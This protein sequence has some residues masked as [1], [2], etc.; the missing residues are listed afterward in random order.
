MNADFKKI[1]AMF[2]LFAAGTVVMST[3]AG[4]ELEK[5]SNET[6]IAFTRIFPS[7]HLLRHAF[8]DDK[9]SQALDFFIKALDRER[10]YF[11][12]SDIDGFNRSR[13]EL[14]DMVKAGDV[15][16]VFDVADTW[17]RRISNRCD[18][19]IGIVSNGFDLSVD[20]TIERD[21]KDA[22]WP[23]DEANWDEIWRKRI[24]DD[25]LRRTLA[26]EMAAES[27]TNKTALTNDHATAIASGYGEFREIIS[28]TEP[29]RILEMFLSSI[30]MAYDPH[31]SYMSPQSEKDFNDEMKLSF[32]GIGAV[33]TSEGG[34]TKVDRV[35]PGGPADRDKRDICL[36]AGDKIIAVAQGDDGPAEDVRHWPVYRVVRLIRGKKGTKVVLTVIPVSDP[37]GTTTRRVDLV[38]DDIPLEQQAAKSE[39]RV[40]TNSTGVAKT[41]GI[42]RLPAFY[43]DMQGRKEGKKDF[44]SSTRD[45]AAILRGMQESNRVDGVILDLRGNGGGAL[46][47]AVEMTGLF[48][49]KGPVVQVW[50][51]KGLALL[52]DLDGL[53]T[54]D[55]PLVVL[56]N[57]HTASASEIVAAALQDFGRAVIIGDSKTH[58]KG[59]V[60]TILPLGGDPPY[61]SMKVTTALFYRINGGSTQ[62]NGVAPDIVLPSALD[63]LKTGEEYLDNPLMWT[64]RRGVTY[65]RCGNLADMVARLEKRSKVRLAGNSRFGVYTNLLSRLAVI[66]DSEYMPLDI[67]KRREMARGI[68][69]LNDKLVEAESGGTGG[70]DVKPAGDGE[71]KDRDIVLNEALEILSDLADMA[72]PAAAVNPSP[73]R[74]SR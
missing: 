39:V 56:V 63:N 36:K 25:Y 62:L 15:S 30:A 68:K 22:P 66:Q 59:S 38:R 42:I 73:G 48:I 27:S 74:E 54:W 60:Q 10:V 72:E 41:A 23:R 58:G 69:E 21:R 9:S 5:K 53:V 16:F 20:E 31:C 47:E 64:M 4:G 28:R 40:F 6:A 12:Q 44:R 57:R 19:V 7:Q 71:K 37:D 65:E 50:E 3:D 43:S 61:G 24:K 18:Y 14:D 26:A 34:F 17:M 52:G 51:S 1:T 13:L 29:D 55:G 46:N 67:G 32:A 2:L 33:L 49:T 45:V 70:N 35:M 11:L 8:D